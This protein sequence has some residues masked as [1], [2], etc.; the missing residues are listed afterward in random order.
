VITSVLPPIRKLSRES[1]IGG[2]ENADLRD[3]MPRQ[4]KEMLNGLQ[5]KG[6]PQ[7]NDPDLSLQRPSRN[8]HKFQGSSRQFVPRQSVRH[9]GNPNP[10]AYQAL[11]DL[12]SAH[13]H[14]GSGLHTLRLEPLCDHRT[15]VGP[16]IAK[17]EIA[18][19]QILLFYSSPREGMR[20]RSDQ[21][22][23]IRNLSENAHSQ[24]QR[25]A[26]HK[27]EIDLARSES[28]QK[29]RASAWLQSQLDV[30]VLA[31]VRAKDGRHNGVCGRDRGSDSKIAAHALR[32]VSDHA[33]QR[34]SL[35][36]QCLQ[37]RS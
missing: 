5:G 35:A 19:P 13:L 2:F 31:T 24:R 9:R 16:S 21:H 36:H 18:A 1:G 12:G 32:Q 33:R 3:F 37:P 8:L 17:N 4:L 30:R 20:T 10:G 28:F 29:T 27:G 23:L 7:L 22:H 11:G 34:F 26:A 25:L 15:S 14:E 6:F